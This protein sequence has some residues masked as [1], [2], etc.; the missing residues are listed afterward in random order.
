VPEFESGSPAARLAMLGITLPEITVPLAAYVSAER[1]GA[2]VYTWA[3]CLG[4]RDPSGH[5][6]GRSRR[7][8]RRS[9][10]LPADL[11]GLSAKDGLPVRAVAPAS[12]RSAAMP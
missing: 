8:R 1:T 9:Q 11:C 10:G 7:R 5:R 6:Q 12:A 2:Y 3:S 4:G